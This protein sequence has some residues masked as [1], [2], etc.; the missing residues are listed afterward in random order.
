[1]KKH[2]LSGIRIYMHKP[3]TSSLGLMLILKKIPFDQTQFELYL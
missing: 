2:E 1:M 3:K